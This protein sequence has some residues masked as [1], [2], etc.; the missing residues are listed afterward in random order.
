MVRFYESLK[1][2]DIAPAHALQIAQHH[3]RG[4]AVGSQDNDVPREIYLRDLSRRSLGSNLRDYRH[5]FYWA[6]F[7]LVG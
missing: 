1:S 6:P 7:I 5:P 2:G 3:L 4:L